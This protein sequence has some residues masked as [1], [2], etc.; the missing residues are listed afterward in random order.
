MTPCQQA[1]EAA[2]KVDAPVRVF[3]PLEMQPA[4]R[5]LQLQVTGKMVPDANYWS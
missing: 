2:R 4:E 5:Q 1:T 3:A